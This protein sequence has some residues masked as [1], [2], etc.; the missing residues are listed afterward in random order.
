MKDSTFKDSYIEYVTLHVP[1]EYIDNYKNDSFWGS[2]FKE[3]VAIDPNSVVLPNVERDS[4]VVYDLNG[5]RV[6]HPTSGLYIVN[7]K[8]VY[9]R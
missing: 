6:S 5:R 7:G 3:I 1:A 2:S 9:V 8:K 4:P